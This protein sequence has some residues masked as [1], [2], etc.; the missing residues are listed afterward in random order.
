[1]ASAPVIGSIPSI[2]HRMSN[3]SQREKI[4]FL[5]SSGGKILPR[6]GDGKLRYVG[7]ETHIFSI[8]KNMSFDEFLKRVILQSASH[9]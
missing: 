9:D 6:P 2:P 4:K 3:D 5:C 1:M 8:Q 7:G